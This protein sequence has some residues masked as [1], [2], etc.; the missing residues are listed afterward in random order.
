V[1]EDDLKEK[2][3][4][5]RSEAARL[6]GKARSLRKTLA[7]R[8]NGAK[9]DPESHKRG[10]NWKGTKHGPRRMVDNDQERDSIGDAQS[11]TGGKRPV[12]GA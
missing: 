7:A 8:E 10:G 5:A 2:E 1:L 12:D 9:G 4:R 6:M 3:R 11:S